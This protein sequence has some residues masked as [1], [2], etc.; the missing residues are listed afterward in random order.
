MSYA[1]RIQVE[2]VDNLP[3]AVNPDCRLNV[4]FGATA[5]MG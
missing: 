1:M 2:N 5:D 4:R 3:T